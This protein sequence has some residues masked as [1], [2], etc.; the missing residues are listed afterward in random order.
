MST[1]QRIRQGGAAA[2]MLALLGACAGNQFGNILGGVLGG[3]AQSGQHVSQ[4]LTGPASTVQLI[5]HGRTERK[6]GEGN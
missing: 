6:K 2:L 4:Q 1:I 5:E 3:G